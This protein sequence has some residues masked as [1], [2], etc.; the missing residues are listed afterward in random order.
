MEAAATEQAKSIPSLDYY[1]K[2]AH[3]LSGVFPVGAFLVEH[4]WTNSQAISGPEHFDRAVKAIQDLPIL[5]FLEVGFIWLPI[6]FHALLGIY[7]TLSGR[8]NITRYPH[9]AN[10]SYLMQRVSGFVILPFL[11][12]HF[13]EFRLNPAGKVVT[14]A[15]SAELLAPTGVK[16][17][18]IVFLF[19]VCYHFFN[20][21]WNF[22]CKWGITTGPRSQQ[23]MAIVMTICGIL[24]FGYS[25]M[26]LLAFK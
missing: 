1:I 14:F 7:I 3:S 19:A 18:Y 25:V 11:A 15:R 5:I 26:T 22:M 9:G 16:L 21:L 23:R 8:V 12:Y 6:A 10:F 4:I 17:A 20:G 13:Y 2:K 24:F